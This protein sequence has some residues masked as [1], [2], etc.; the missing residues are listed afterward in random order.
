MEI[1]SS[2]EN[3]EKNMMRI[4]DYIYENDAKKIHY[5]IPEDIGIFK[6]TTAAVF[7]YKYKNELYVSYD[8]RNNP[9]NYFKN[10]N[11]EYLCKKKYT[12]DNYYMNINALYNLDTFNKYYIFFKNMFK[13]IIGLHDEC[14]QLMNIINLVNVDKLNKTFNKYVFY[15]F[16]L[17]YK[18][19]QLLDDLDPSLLGKHVV[20]NNNVLDNKC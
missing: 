13:N 10:T 16:M 20:I 19:D 15:Y 18:K 2:K 7:S 6:D 8:K 1:T 12:G 17:Y 14:Y 11:S 3:Y 4:I 5:E 9:I